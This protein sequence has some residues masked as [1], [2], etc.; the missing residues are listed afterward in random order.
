[1]K[2]FS[3]KNQ[4]ECTEAARSLHTAAE[5]LETFVDNPQ[6]AAVPAK[7]STSGAAAQQPVLVSGREMLDASCEMIMTAKQLAL[8]PT[9]ASTW[10]RLADNSKVVSE[11]IKRLVASIRDQAPGQVRVNIFCV[12]SEC[13]L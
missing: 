13:S 4:R 5:Q 9:D 2:F 11:S 7:I 8:S 12:N 1:M 10:Q 6:F 3:E